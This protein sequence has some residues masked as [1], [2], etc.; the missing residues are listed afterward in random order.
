MQN[1]AIGNS[2]TVH[3]DM[4]HF[5]LSMFFFLALF[6]LAIWLSIPRRK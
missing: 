3:V 5:A 2:I 6:V 4:P 1:V